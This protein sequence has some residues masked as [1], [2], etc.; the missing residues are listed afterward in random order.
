MT[1]EWWQT[2]DS[3][4]HM[5]LQR[6]HITENETMREVDFLV[7]IAHLDPG[8]RIL[9]LA[10]GSGRH[11]IELGKRGYNVTGIDYTGR[12]LGI[13]NESSKKLTTNTSFLQANMIQVPFKNESFDFV[14][15]MWQSLGYFQSE[16]DNFK[17]FSEIARI[18]K[19]GGLC[20]LQVNNPLYVLNDLWNNPATQDRNSELFL[21]QED[22]FE[23]TSTKKTTSFSPTTFRNKSERTYNLPTGEVVVSHD[24]RYYSLPEL[25][26]ILSMVGMKCKIAF[27]SMDGE[28]YCSK[29]RNIIV[30][31]Q[32]DKTNT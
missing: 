8:S 27:G 14:M 30:L 32:K 13:A 22:Y 29:S 16:E 15:S 25:K 10:C 11:V 18:T 20:F 4:T 31:A 17:V 9:D 7:G 6:H 12:L 28:E 19:E 24:M 1:K 23:G 3:D 5:W 21:E 26:N 2:I